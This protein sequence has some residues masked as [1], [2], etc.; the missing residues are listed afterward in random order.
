MRRSTTIAVLWSLTLLAPVGAQ[1]TTPCGERV[2]RDWMDGR[3]EGRYAPHC[4]GEALDTLP[5]DVRAYSTAED[6]I[7]QALRARIRETRRP[8]PAQPDAMAATPPSGLSRFTTPIPLA[9]VAAAAITL[10][11]SLALFAR[12]VGSRLRRARLAHRS[13]R[14]IGEW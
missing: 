14:P 4:Y 8:T 13:T 1:A 12:F 9:L 5:E 2:V 10:L 11:L 7:A 6:D 3:I